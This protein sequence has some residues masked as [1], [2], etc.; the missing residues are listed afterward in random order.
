VHR[1]AAPRGAAAAGGAAAGGSAEARAAAAAQ[2][3]LLEGG[4]GDAAA[5]AAA[6]AAEAAA[7]AAA[8]ESGAAPL[9][10][11]AAAAPA[12]IVLNGGEASTVTRADGRFS[13]DGLAPGV[14]LVEAFHERAVFSTFKVQVPAD[15]SAPIAALEYR[16][17]GAPK[18]PA[19]VPL[20]LLPV[21][22][23]GP[24]YFDERPRATILAFAMQPMVL[25]VRRPSPTPSL[26]LFG[27]S[28]RLRQH[29]RR[30][31]SR[32]RR[33]C[34]RAAP[35]L[36]R[37]GSRLRLLSPHLVP[38][39]AAPRRAAHHCRAPCSAPPSL[40]RPLFPLR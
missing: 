15:A 38:S 18:L 12:R 17:P 10:G 3:A 4:G 25:M 14:Y 36:R 19:R 28:R 6:A 27:P 20:E 35:W 8:D 1:R 7:Q 31:K 39:R 30:R 33:R 34:R 22:P 29:C 11:A 2:R 40:A 16:Y 13:F 26:P 5:A 21:T 32:L 24:L 23:Q 37:G 9:A